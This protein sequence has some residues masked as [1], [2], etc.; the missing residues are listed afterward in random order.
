MAVSATVD[1]Y[2]GSRGIGGANVMVTMKE[3]N[4]VMSEAST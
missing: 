1:G 3:A 2:R 4:N